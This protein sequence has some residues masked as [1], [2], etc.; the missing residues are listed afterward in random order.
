M[1]N[2]RVIELAK[3][4][5]ALADRGIDGEKRNAAEL[6]NDFLEKHGLTLDDIESETRVDTFINC[7]KK[8][9]KIMAQIFWRVL[10]YDA[11]IYN[12]AGKRYGYVIECTPAEKIEIAAMFRHYWAAYEREL[13]S[14]QR[15]FIMTNNLYAQ[16]AD[17]RDY[18]DLTQQEK[19]EF[20][21][22]QRLAQG[23]DKSEF[24]KQL[25]D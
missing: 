5:K 10:G 11:K 8:Q 18:D 23:M 22:A 14:F 15:A 1:S 6:L 9:R 12:S 7:Q 17:G 13:E 25:N 2:H 3:K 21:R 24:F 19:D 20:E 4:I 16:D